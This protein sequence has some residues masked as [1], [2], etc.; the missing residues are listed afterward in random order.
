MMDENDDDDAGL[1]PRPPG[2]FPAP[3]VTR[4]TDLIVELSVQLVFVAVSLLGALL[5][6]EVHR[7]MRQHNIPP[8]KAADLTPPPT[9]DH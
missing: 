1:G 4:A 6:H 8:Q 7:Y 2:S 3:D 5:I 9:D